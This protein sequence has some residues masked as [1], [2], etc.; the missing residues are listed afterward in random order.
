MTNPQKDLLC[1][2][3]QSGYVCE[4]LAVWPGGHQRPKVHVWSFMF[5]IRSHYLC[6][7]LTVASVHVAPS[8]DAGSLSVCPPVALDTGVGLLC[9]LLEQWGQVPGGVLA[10]TE[11]LLGEE[12]SGDEEAAE[13]SSLVRIYD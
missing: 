8:S 5:S 1:V 9:G 13:F 10:L 4:K 2:R 6:H 7:S 11:W 3:V 12:E